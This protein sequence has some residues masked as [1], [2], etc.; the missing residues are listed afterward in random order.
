M[1]KK[2]KSAFQVDEEVI[3][4][5]RSAQ[6]RFDEERLDPKRNDAVFELR[7]ELASPAVVTAE[8][9][10]A[11]AVGLPTLDGF[12]SYI[13][14]RAAVDEVLKSNPDIA[15]R[16]LWQWNVGLRDSRAWVDFEFAYSET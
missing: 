6:W 16:V 10:N 7:L 11:P 12:L 14:F 5:L 2:T 3:E 9:A 15:Q 13:A 4:E 1:A 8:K